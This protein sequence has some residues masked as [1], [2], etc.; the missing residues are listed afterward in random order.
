MARSKNL[1]KGENVAKSCNF[2]SRVLKQWR[3]HQFCHDEG[4]S[5]SFLTIAL[6][7]AFWKTMQRNLVEQT[8]NLLA[9]GSLKSKA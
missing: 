4:F 7:V 3:Y 9:A 2:L 6:S 1:S 8:L 5:S